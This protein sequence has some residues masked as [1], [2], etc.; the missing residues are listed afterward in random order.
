MA[1]KEQKWLGVLLI[2]L[3]TLSGV[4][5]IAWPDAGVKMRVDDDRS[6]FYMLLDGSWTVVARE[7]SS[8]WDGSSKINRDLSNTYTNI[9]FTENA[10]STLIT[11]VTTYQR[12]PVIV[13]TYVFL[14]NETDIKNFPY[15]H[16]I[17]IYNASGLIYQYE[18]RDL[19]FYTGETIK[20]VES[21]LRAGRVFVEWVKGDYWNTVYQSGVLKVR[22]RVETDFLLLKN[23]VYDPPKEYVVPLFSADLIRQAYNG[24]SQYK[25]KCLNSF[26]EL[27]IYILLLESS[28]IQGAFE[29]E[30]AWYKGELPKDI[31]VTIEVMEEVPMMEYKLCKGCGQSNITNGTADTYEPFQVNRTRWVEHTIEELIELGYIV[32]GNLTPGKYI[33]NYKGTMQPGSSLDIIPM[34]FGVSKEVFKM[35]AGWKYG[36]T[37]V[38]YYTFDDNETHDGLNHTLWSGCLNGTAGNLTGFGGVTTGKT[39][40]V[41][42][43]WFFDGSASG[44]ISEFNTG[45]TGTADRTIGG[46]FNLTPDS[47]QN[48]IMLMLGNGSATGSAFALFKANDN[49]V[50]LWGAGA[51][52][53]PDTGAPATKEWEFWVITY[54]HSAANKISIYRNG[55]LVGAGNPSNTINTVEYRL[56]VMYRVGAWPMIGMVDE[57]FVF[58]DVW[59][60]D[61]VMAA[62]VNGT[63]SLFTLNVD[64][65]IESLVFNAS[66]FNFLEP[67][68]CSGIVTDA[69][70]HTL[71]GNISL[72]NTTTILNWTFFSSVAN[73]TTVNATLNGSDYDYNRI[74]SCNISVTDSYDAGP[75]NAANTTTIFGI[76]MKGNVSVY[77]GSLIVGANVT[78][79]SLYDDTVYG[80]IVTNSTG[81]WKLDNLSRGWYMPYAY[82]KGNVTRDADAD[83][84]IY[85]G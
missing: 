7:Q 41:G 28:P 15:T 38:A 37:C 83:P 49:K 27:P 21:P 11:R 55:S 72:W 73:G 6:T 12:G 71:T 48:E 56:Q 59:T 32:E 2:T 79:M 14:G 36:M 22:W 24:S 17:A 54:N 20:G 84:H 81:G 29:Y 9:T 70:N 80:R 18:V 5:Y 51:D 31:H 34:P 23:R 47:G 82:E 39:G 67:M 19:R 3:F 65:V 63:R 57:L 53:N 60:S 69:D 35:W 85:I 43:A 10:N 8:L 61:Q 13:D 16:E 66:T 42:E 44:A 46:W 40:K 52:Y 77:N 50:K 33:I 4:V 62:Y 68:T 30:I 45:I 78:V 74:I 1:T 58:A 76:A 25:E 64:P 75:I 26:C